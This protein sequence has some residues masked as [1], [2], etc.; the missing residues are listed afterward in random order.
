MTGPMRLVF[1]DVDET[2]VDVKT[3]FDFLAYYF[4]GVYGPKGTRF[5]ERVRRDLVA[6]AAAGTPREVGSRVYYRA[7]TGEP[8]ARVQA[9]AAAWFAERSA[10]PG[11]FLAA[12]RR[13]LDLHRERGAVVVLVSGSFPAVLEPIAAEIGAAHL[14]CSVPETLDG[15]LT[16]EL[17]GEPLIGEAKRAAVRGMLR[18]H[19]A[20]DPADCHAYGDHISDLPMLAEVGHP[21]VVGDSAELVAALPHARVLGSGVGSGVEAPQ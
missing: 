8:A 12:T 17:V 1:S 15:V 20:A 2:L 14:L 3:M 7:W 16:G 9:R 5:A 19:P 13:A 6:R 4:T 18:R 21:V 10:D 11:F